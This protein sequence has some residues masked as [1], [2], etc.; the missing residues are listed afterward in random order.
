LNEIQIQ[1]N[2]IWIQNWIKIQLKNEMQIGE[3]GTE[4]LL[5]HLVLEFF[6]QKN[7]ITN[8]FPCLFIYKWDA[9][10]NCPNDNLQLMK[11]EVQNQFWWII[12][13]GISWAG[14]QIKNFFS[15]NLFDWLITN[16][17]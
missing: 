15:M 12:V 14:F 17:F 8:T 6:K 9:L 5:I 10:W 1:L 7:F 16:K 4:N 13:S 2:L 3:E 11:C